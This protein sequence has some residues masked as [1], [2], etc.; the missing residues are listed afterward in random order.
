MKN[1]RGKSKLFAILGICT[2]VLLV[3]SMLISA[4]ND[5]PIS[6]EVNQVVEEKTDNSVSGDVSAYVEDFVEKKGINP[7][8]INNISKVDFDSLPKEVNIENV[9]DANL[10]IYQI[11]YNKSASSNNKIFVVTYSV[12]KLKAQ[13]DIIVSQDKRE[14]LNFGFSGEMDSSGFLK[15]AS[16][17]ST[18]L[19]RGYVMMRSGSITGISTSL[20]LL[21]GSGNVEIVIYKNGNQINFGNTLIADSAG[22]KEDYDT[23]SKGTVPFEAGDIISAYLKSSEGISLKD[24]T[25]LIEITT[26]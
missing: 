24:V 14:F 11:D 16:G 26:N 18:D 9:N 4:A 3:A 19:E 1:K 20:D 7:N 2:I 15:S 13:G 6:E 25:A 17:V 21:K 22:V 12:D 5:A 8:E 23:Q 10:A